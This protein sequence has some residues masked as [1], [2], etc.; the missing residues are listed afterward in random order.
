[1]G[2][3]CVGLTK[4]ILPD[5]PEASGQAAGV[6]RGRD[7]SRSQRAAVGEDQGKSRPGLHPPSL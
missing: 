3:P 4:V 6:Q 1:M 2:F 7:H 5:R